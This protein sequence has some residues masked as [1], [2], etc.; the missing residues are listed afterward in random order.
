MFPA[1]I[2]KYVLGAMLLGLPDTCPRLSLPQHSIPP[3]WFREQVC[4]LPAP[5]VWH[6][7]GFNTTRGVEEALLLPAMSSSR[8][9]ADP[10][11]VPFFPLRG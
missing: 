1:L 10:R 11:Q 3:I 9:R 5:R 8:S 7:E 2:V 4:S 6:C